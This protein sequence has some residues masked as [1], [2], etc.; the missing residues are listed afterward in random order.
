[1]WFKYSFGIV[2]KSQIK[3]ISELQINNYKEPVTYKTFVQRYGTTCWSTTLRFVERDSLIIE[4][5]SLIRLSRSTNLKKIKIQ[6]SEFF[7]VPFS[8]Q[9]HFE[10]VGLYMKRFYMKHILVWC[11]FSEFQSTS[12]VFNRCSV[13]VLSTENVC[14]GNNILAS[15]T[16]RRKFF[17]NVC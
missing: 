10:L 15:D 17:L 3:S 16:V 13:F 9:K 8:Q 1:M 5:P 14:A 4:R 6:N 12:G 7:I 2:H 11:K